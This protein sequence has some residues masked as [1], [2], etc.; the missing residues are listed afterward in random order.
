M[1]VGKILFKQSSVVSHHPPP[2]Q[3]KINRLTPRSKHV[4]WIVVVPITK[5]GDWPQERW[6]SCWPHHQILCQIDMQ[7]GFHPNKLH[8]WYQIIL[9]SI[10][11]C[12]LII[13]IHSSN[14]I[15][16]DNKLIISYMLSIHKLW[17]ETFRQKIFEFLIS[18]RD[19]IQ[20]HETMKGTWK[21][22]KK[23]KICKTLPAPCLTAWW[24]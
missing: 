4:I 9:Q 17:Q 6:A 11:I 5:K 18:T 22:H 1:P 3:N 12:Y 24:R 20:F 19:Q 10:V 7:A 13:K 23:V 2:F 8:H 21:T 15:Y 16:D 14:Y